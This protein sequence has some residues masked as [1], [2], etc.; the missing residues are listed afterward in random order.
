MASTFN[1]FDFLVGAGENPANSGKKK[2]KAKQK[3]QRSEPVA[4][5]K[6][7]D[8]TSA[9]NAAAPSAASAALPVA[10]VT[11]R[12]EMAARTATTPTD[13]VKLWKD[14]CRQA[15]DTKVAKRY[16][17]VS[18]EL[19]EFKAVLLR[20][21][22]LEITAEQAISQPIGQQHDELL[23]FDKLLATFLPLDQSRT[24]YLAGS[25]VKLGQLLAD[26]APDSMG[27][28][29]RAMGN[30]IQRLKLSSSESTTTFDADGITKWLEKL[31]KVDADIHNELTMLQKLSQAS[32]A[33]VTKER[34]QCALNVL[35]LQ[36]Q[37]VNLLHPDNAP[38]LEGA[39]ST[40]NPAVTALTELH[41]VVYN[42]LQEAESLE[43]S[44]RSHAA[45]AE[46]QMAQSRAA[47]QREE[48][49]LSKQ[50]AEL[51]S[52]ITTLEAQLKAL[53]MQAAEIDQRRT[54]LKKRISPSLSNGAGSQLQDNHGSTDY[55]EQLVTVD[56]LLDLVDP[57]RHGAAAMD[58]VWE[59]Q[60]G[61]AAAAAEY[62]NFA[63]ECL[64]MN[65]ALLAETPQKI[66]FSKQRIAQAEKLVLLTAAAAKNQDVNKKQKEDAEKL[67]AETMKSA[68][69]IHA[70]SDAIVRSVI[71]RHQQLA[72]VDPASAGGLLPHVAAV[73]E[74]FVRVGQ[75]YTTV[76]ACY[77]QAPAP[78]PVPQRAPRNR[79]NDQ[80][81]AA[82]AAAPAAQPAPA[83]PAPADTAAPAAVAAP[84]LKPKPAPVPTSTRQW[85]KPVQQAEVAAEGA[86]ALPTPAEAF[87]G[88]ETSDGFHT[89]SSGRNRR[90]A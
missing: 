53:K 63:Q 54:A 49:A 80:A 5:S 66:N 67:L 73:E 52:Q 40:N 57:N 79:R 76:M 90:K 30:V 4:D 38:R 62:I 58:Q 82:P 8:D 18:G 44:A 51:S 15:G 81:A 48:A 7:P 33:T 25:I 24:S 42:H 74:M 85:A 37:K 55:K 77:D 26:G 65:L 89:V 84:A 23:Q 68:E 69:E 64:G 9:R 41:A 6:A 34:V 72:A 59:A 50:A 10:E 20:S 88:A 3:A 39:A 12:L 56:D 1:A 14:W 43:A 28:A 17:D 13:R 16:Q 61:Q 35:K 21:K 31:K 27:A 19:L 83:A 29:R 45:Y 36:E 71:A 32:G 22:A 2:S 75:Q 87:R 46:A 86:E 11:T 47:M 60:A 78:M 70:Q